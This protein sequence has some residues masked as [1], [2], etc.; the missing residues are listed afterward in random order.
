MFSSKNCISKKDRCFNIAASCMI[1]QDKCAVRIPDPP[2][3]PPCHGQEQPHG[4]L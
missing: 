3:L 2:S 1:W 4:H